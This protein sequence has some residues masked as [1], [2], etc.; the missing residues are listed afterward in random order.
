MCLESLESKLHRAN[1]F[2]NSHPDWDISRVGKP[3]AKATAILFKSVSTV[4]RFHLDG[5]Q[6]SYEIIIYLKLIETVTK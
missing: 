5:K 2:D 4:E 6:C 1:Y 3:L